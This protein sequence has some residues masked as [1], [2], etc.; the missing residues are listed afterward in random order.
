MLST[1]TGAVCW[2]TP[3]QWAWHGFHWLG[4]LCDQVIHG[5]LIGRAAVR[6]DE[7][8]RPWSACG[9]LKGQIMRPPAPALFCS[10]E[11][12]A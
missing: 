12:Q 5:P 8:P 7:L 11:R 6:E 4:V 3:W 9:L 1:V 2:R 10:G